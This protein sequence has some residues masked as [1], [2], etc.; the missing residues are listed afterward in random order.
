LTNSGT[1]SS[2]VLGVD[3]GTTAG[4]V[5]AGNDSRL[6]DARTPTSHASTHQTGGADA[7]SIVGSQITSGT[8]DNARLTTRARAAINIYMWSSFR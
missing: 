4:T 5:A 8:L 6:S 3:V 1:A 2:A 7:L